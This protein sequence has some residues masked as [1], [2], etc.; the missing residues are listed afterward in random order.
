MD[1]QRIKQLAGIKLTESV[2]AVPGIGDT[3]S[4][5]QTAGTV[6]R[7]EAYAAF[8]AAQTPA[9]ESVIDFNDMNSWDMK[10]LVAAFRTGQISNAEYEKL[11]DKAINGSD[12][13]DYTDTTMRRGEMGNYSRDL[14]PDID[15]SAPPG[16]EDTVMKLKKEYP[17][18]EEKAFATAWSIYNK[19]HGKTE[20]AACTMDEADVS[21]IDP[22]WSFDQLQAAYR[23]GDITKYEYSIALDNI[24]YPGKHDMTMSSPDL[25]ADVEDPVAEDVFNNGY[26]SDEYASGVDFFPNG[27]DSPV[28][29]DVGPSGARQ[30]DNPEQKKMQV[31]EVH[32][33]LVYGYRNFLK[34]TAAKKSK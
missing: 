15:E 14:D 32:K 7:D 6:G 5:M 31:A 2:Q 30:G 24:L 1:L 27:A 22:S 11:L 16:M 10:D 29:T 19:K 18:E 21:K 33:E 26:D 23:N 13:Y 28:V 34:E 20:E 17:G 9:T 8:D 3:E 4:D 25:A 12:D